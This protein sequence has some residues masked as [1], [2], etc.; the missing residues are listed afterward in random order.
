MNSKNDKS[1]ASI[2]ALY[3]EIERRKGNYKKALKY[4]NKAIKFDEYND[5]YLASRSLT[6]QFLLDRNGALQD[7]K[8]AYYLQNKV[9]LYLYIRN[10]ILNSPSHKNKFYDRVI[11]K[12]IS[13]SYYAFNGEVERRK[14]NYKKALKYLNAAIMLDEYNDIYYASRCMCKVSLRNIVG[15]AE[16]INK[17]LS[18][19][20]N[21]LL[22]KIIKKKFCS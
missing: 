12:S 17:S 19:Q 1:K 8:K 10:E 3:G 18:L 5:I 11:N 7:I 4:L 20:N 6:K 2:Y 13:P 14:R 21:V 9:T 15:A 16:D 22:Y